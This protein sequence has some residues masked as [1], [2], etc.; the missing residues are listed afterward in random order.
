[1]LSIKYVNLVKISPVFLEIQGAEISNFMVLANNSHVCV[2]LG[3]RH[4]TLCVLITHTKCLKWWMKIIAFL[5][6]SRHVRSRLIMSDNV[7]T[8]SS[9]QVL[10]Q[11]LCT[12]EYF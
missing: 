7:Q 6:P 5:L 8:M 4:T 1:M 12:L 10:F 11:A 3:P 9:C 2:F